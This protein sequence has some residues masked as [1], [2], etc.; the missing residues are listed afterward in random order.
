MQT[1]DPRNNSRKNDQRDTT[2]PALGSLTNDDNDDSED[3]AKNMNLHPF[4]LCRVYL[5]LPNLTNDVGDFPGVESLRTLSKLKKRQE[6]SSSSVHVL[7]K[8]LH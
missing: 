5:N 8:T 7:Y 3:V 2:L 6:N 1:E 4:T